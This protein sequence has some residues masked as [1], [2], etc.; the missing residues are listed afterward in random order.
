MLHLAISCK[1]CR[2]KISKQVAEQVAYSVTAPLKYIGLNVLI[3]HTRYITYMPDT[4]VHRNIHTCPQNHVA[5]LKIRQFKLLSKM[6]ASYR[7]ENS[8]GAIE[9][10]L[11]Q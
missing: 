5:L 1:L 11:V 9:V 3:I 4:S 6:K 7:L 10:F 2:N 8:L